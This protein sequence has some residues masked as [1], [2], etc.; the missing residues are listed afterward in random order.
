M[1]WLNDVRRDFAF[2]ARSKRLRELPHAAGIRWQQRRAKVVGFR[3]GWQF[4]R[5][6]HIY[7]AEKA[8]A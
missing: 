5:S 7:R 6:R 3:D 1:G 4:Y 8:N 2:C